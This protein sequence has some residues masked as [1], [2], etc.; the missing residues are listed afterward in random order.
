MSTSARHVKSTF[1]VM[2][3]VRR[4]DRYWSSE[5]N[6]T[7]KW[8]L[9]RSLGSGRNTLKRLD[10]AVETCITWWFW[11]RELMAFSAHIRFVVQRT[12]VAFGRFVLRSFGL[13]HC[14]VREVGTDVSK[15]MQ[16]LSSGWRRPK[17]GKLYLCRIKL[18]KY[19]LR[20]TQL[21]VYVIITIH[22]AV[23]D[24]VHI[25]FYFINVL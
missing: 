4:Y 16:F 6:N 11:D 7:R 8:P 10:G 23:S 24:G 9:L 25:Y 3:S 17:V 5:P 18:I 21:Y 12:V 22:V 15:E 20:L 13:L 2:T 1:I 19:V 14:S